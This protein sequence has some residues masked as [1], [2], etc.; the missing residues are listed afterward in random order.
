M[1]EDR[2]EAVVVRS[3]VAVAA[4]TMLLLSASSAR[5]QSRVFTGMVTGHLGAAAN[6]DVRDW[7]VAPGASMNVIDENGLG[8]ELDLS[9]IGDFDT[10]SFADSS[11]TTAML[12]FKFLYPHGRVRPFLV[13]GAGVMRVR[14]TLFPGQSSISQTDNA[15]N[16]GGGVIYMLN[17]AIGL[18]GDV[19]YF[20]HFG[21]QTNLPLADNGG[22]EFVRSSFGVSFSW[23]LE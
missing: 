8:A 13:A 1:V 19:R 15:W 9:H 10:A 16:A 7:A 17:E 23:P 20:R 11:I 5:A 2:R 22:L 3:R 6:G 12:N 21:R 18:R 4:V 14:V